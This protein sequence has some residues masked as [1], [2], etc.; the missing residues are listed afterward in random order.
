MGKGMG[1]ELAEKNQEVK[2]EVSWESV[3]LWQHKQHKNVWDTY[4][5]VP[6]RRGFPLRWEGGHMFDEK[7]AW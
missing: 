7:V 2:T 4:G 3:K 1:M 6:I 5:S